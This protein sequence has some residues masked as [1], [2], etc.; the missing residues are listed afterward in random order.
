VAVDLRGIG[1]TSREDEHAYAKYLGPLWR[2]A[3]TAYLLGT[4]CLAM[5]AEDIL[6]CARFA[7]TYETSGAPNR[8]HLISLGRVGPPALHAVAF[9][10]EQFATARFQRCL[11]SWAEVVRTPLAVRQLENT[12]HG[13]LRVYDLPDLTRTLP[14]DRFS[15]IDPANAFGNV[16]AAGD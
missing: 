3:F 13:A 11:S 12:V 16:Q 5:R 9:E 15:F 7:A 2:E 10:P 4:S 14:A 8:V 1:E 6:V